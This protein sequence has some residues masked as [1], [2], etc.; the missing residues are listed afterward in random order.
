M[1]NCTEVLTKKEPALCNILREINRN[2]LR[3]HKSRLN[4]SKFK[5]INDKVRNCGKDSKKLF[6]LVSSLTRNIKNNMLP[7]KSDDLPNKCMHFF[8]N[9]INKVRTNLD[10]HPLCDPP[11]KR[12]PMRIRHFYRNDTRRSTFNSYE[13]QDNIL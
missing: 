13:N 7:E 3:P 1:Q 2:I 9:K 12:S 8:L 11:S 6:N 10:T 4:S 5:Y